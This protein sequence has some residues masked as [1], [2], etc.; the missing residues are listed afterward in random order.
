MGDCHPS[1]KIREM[2]GFDAGGREALRGPHCAAFSALRTCCRCTCGW[3]RGEDRRPLLPVRRQ[4]GRVKAV[5]VVSG[6]N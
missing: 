5:P 4:E 6:S 1:G 3:C 2:T